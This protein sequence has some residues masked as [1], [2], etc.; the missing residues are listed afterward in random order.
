MLGDEVRSS[1]F[2]GDLK[3]GL[4]ELAVLH[5]EGRCSTMGAVKATYV[6][7]LIFHLNF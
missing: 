3:Q 7:R 5:E 6:L 1:A 4:K 2:D